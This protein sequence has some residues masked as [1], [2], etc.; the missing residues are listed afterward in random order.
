MKSEECFDSGEGWYTR[1]FTVRSP[2]Y[3]AGERIS[4][5]QQLVFHHRGGLLVP[6]NSQAAWAQLLL[7]CFAVGF[8]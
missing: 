5:F 4:L 7:L 8:L 6:D 2:G 3:T 1:A